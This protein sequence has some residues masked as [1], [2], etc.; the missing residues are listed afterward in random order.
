MAKFTSVSTVRALSLVAGTFI[1]GLATVQPV[2]ADQDLAMQLRTSDRE[3]HGTREVEAGNYDAG[4]AKL[5]KALENT[6]SSLRRAP[7]LN[8]LC[9]AYVASGQLENAQAYCDL[10]VESGFE[11]SVAHNN[12]GVLNFVLGNFDASVKDLET[13][14]KVGSQKLYVERNLDLAKTNK[15]A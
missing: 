4:I 15:G 11:Q 1:L 6:G 10:A 14:T 12:R 13:A 9:V 5:H 3:V 8:N 7:I 2:S